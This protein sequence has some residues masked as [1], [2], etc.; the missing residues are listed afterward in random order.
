M[1]QVIAQRSAI[2]CGCIIV[3]TSQ[4]IAVSIVTQFPEETT[5]IIYILVKVGSN[6]CCRLF[7]AGYIDNNGFLAIIIEVA[8]DDIKKCVC[9]IAVDLKVSVGICDPVEGKI[10][11]IGAALLTRYGIGQNGINLFACSVNP[12]IDNIVFSSRTCRVK[13]YRLYKR[14]LLNT[15]RQ[16]QVRQRAVRCG[17]VI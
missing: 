11:N 17:V 13:C 12:D 7:C 4:L 1:K 8:G 6:P 3:I 15:T 10:N 5:D 9:L 2:T 14:K 16:A